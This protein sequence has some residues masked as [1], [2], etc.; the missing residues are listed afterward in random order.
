MLRGSKLKLS[1]EKLEAVA[2]GQPPLSLWANRKGAKW[3]QIL[4]S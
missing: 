1:E 2:W 4:D 3:V